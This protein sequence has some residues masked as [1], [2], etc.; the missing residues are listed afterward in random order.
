MKLTESQIAEIGTATGLSRPTIFKVLKGHETT[1]KATE[2]IVKLAYLD[3]LKGPLTRDWINDLIFEV[4]EEI[5]NYV[6]TF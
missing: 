6:T 4:N 5:D 3:S 1:S 2:Y